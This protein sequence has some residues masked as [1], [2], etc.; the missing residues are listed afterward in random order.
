MVVEKLAISLAPELLA[1]V[2]HD[3]EASGETVS[4]WL[5]DAAVSKLRRRA[6]QL[7]LA[8]FEAEHGVITDDELAEARALWPA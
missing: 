4:G 7:A 3:A 8:A 6:A 1:E 5:A 2:R